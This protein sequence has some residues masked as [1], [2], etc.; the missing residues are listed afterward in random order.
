VRR[1]WIS[2]LWLKWPIDLLD[3][4]FAIPTAIHVPRSNPVASPIHAFRITGTSVQTVKPKA[5]ALLI[6]LIKWAFFY[7]VR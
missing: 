2:P 1:I 6:I 5:V 3:H 7:G 4:N